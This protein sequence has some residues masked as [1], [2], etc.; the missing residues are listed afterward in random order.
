MN[1]LIPSFSGYRG[2]VATCIVALSPQGKTKDLA[3]ISLV[4]KWISNERQR[5]AFAVER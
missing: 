2:G 5:H 4:E 1:K 3:T